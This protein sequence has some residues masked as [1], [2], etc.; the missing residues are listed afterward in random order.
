MQ[1]STSD[2]KPFEVH[3]CL[4]AGDSSKKRT[5]HAT[6]TSSRRSPTFSAYISA[7][8]IMN[9]PIR[10][11]SELLTPWAATADFLR[12][13]MGSGGR[14]SLIRK[15]EKPPTSKTI[16]ASTIR[17]VRQRPRRV[18]TRSAA[19]Q[20]KSFI[21]NQRAKDNCRGKPNRQLPPVQK[22]CEP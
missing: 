22:Y 19:A 11:P 17:E 16:I 5:R 3:P 9:D 8:F 7:A 10:L 21:T 6:P 15:T 13:E 14:P 4:V 12:T 18:S 1:P 2:I 20:R